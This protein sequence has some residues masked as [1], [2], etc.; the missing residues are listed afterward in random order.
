LTLRFEAANGGLPTETAEMAF[1]QID[2]L[3]YNEGE[4]LEEKNV[5]LDGLHSRVL[6]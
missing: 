3:A 4:K 1:M 2:N 5:A 6:G